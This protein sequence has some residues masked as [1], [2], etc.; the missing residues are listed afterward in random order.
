MLIGLS[1]KASAGKDTFA[2]YLQQLFGFTRAAFADPL[3]A[4]A[5]EVFGL[6]RDQL[7]DPVLKSIPDQYWQRTPRELLQQMGVGMREAID[8][9]V[10][11]M[12]TLRKLQALPLAYWVVTDVRFP[13]EA[14]A[15]RHQGG[16]VVR[17]ERPGAGLEGEAGQHE[18]E[19]AL[20]NWELFDAVVQNDGDVLALESKA[21]ELYL[22]LLESEASTG[23]LQSSM[24][25]CGQYLRGRVIG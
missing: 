13:N 4:A 17:I 16:Y 19:T 24:K 10:W 20:D 8:R 5:A 22:K 18:S 3:K 15:I 1:G 23:D 11:V 14:I 12:A 7:Y 9:D 21:A 25:L 6:S 2:F